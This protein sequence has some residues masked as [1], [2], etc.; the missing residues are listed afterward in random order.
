[1]TETRAALAKALDLRDPGKSWHTDRTPVLRIT[2]WLTRLTVAL[3]KPAQDMIL[4]TQTGIEEV[5]LG[6][7]GSSST[8][9]QKQNPVAPSAIV[10]LKNVVTGA[11]STLQSN[12]THSQQ[13]DGAAWFTEWMMVP[14]IAL[15]AV[16]ALTQSQALAQCVT[17]NVDNMRRNLD[18][19]QGTIVAEALSFA[20]ATQMPK[21]EAQAKTKELCATAIELRRP[22]ADVALSAVPELDPNI[23]EPARNTGD[24]ASLANA[25]VDRVAALR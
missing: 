15:G 6:A 8:M 25:F 21:P 24:A 18:R 11:Q 2:D 4:L 5:S 19:A 9:P 13:R 20:L 12:A 3:A 23:F 14:Q 17:A 16:A 7:S 10:A 1:M 22:L